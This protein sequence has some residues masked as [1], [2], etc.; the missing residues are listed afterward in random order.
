M[1][2]EKNCCDVKKPH[3]INIMEHICISISKGF[4]YYNK[5]AEI[6]IFSK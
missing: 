6:F 2:T 4:F 5:D 3:S 1:Q